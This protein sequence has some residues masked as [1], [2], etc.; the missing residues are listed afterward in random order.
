MQRYSLFLHA[1]Y[2]GGAEKILVTIA[3]RLAERGEAVDIVVGNSEGPVQRLVSTDVRIVDLG[4]DRT[5]KAI[6]PLARYLRSERPTALVTISPLAL[7]IGWQE[8]MRD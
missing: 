8:V 4:C 1:F 6:L 7:R 2:G 3:N 5:F